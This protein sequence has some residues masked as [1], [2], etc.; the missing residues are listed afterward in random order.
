MKILLAYDASDESKK[1]VEWAARLA[2]GESRSTITVLG[3][4]HTLEM[5]GAT[6]DAVEPGEH[7]E[8]LEKA[9]HD[10]SSDLTTK[11]P[12]A[13]VK[14]TMLAGNPSEEIINAGRS[15]DVIVVGKS[16]RHGMQ[17]FLIGSVAERVSRH[18]RTPVLIAS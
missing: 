7:P 1:A 2:S 6:R 18:S 9:L 16:G 12:T 17:R 3:V 4:I 8:A 10:V 14:T 13:R 5:G 15:A 11:V